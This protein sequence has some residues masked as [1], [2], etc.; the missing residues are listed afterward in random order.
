MPHD[1]NHGIGTGPRSMWYNMCA[2]W[3]VCRALDYR[4]SRLQ[5][6]R[7]LLRS[8]IVLL[9]VPGLP[10]TLIVV[11]ILFHGINHAFKAGDSWA[12]ADASTAGK[13]TSQSYDTVLG[14]GES[15][16]RVRNNAPAMI[17]LTAAELEALESTAVCDVTFTPVQREL[18]LELRRISQLPE[19]RRA[20]ALERIRPKLE[21]LVARIPDPQRSIIY[22]DPSLKDQY[23]RAEGLP[24]EQRLTE[25]WRLRKIAV[26]RMVK[27]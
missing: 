7:R 3:K 27:R 12:A 24:R 23:V 26:S 25:I 8:V 6:A 13:S 19:T 16:I 15:I 2:E 18:Q 11:S 14:P 4:K 1:G 5:L 20:A 9:L 21:Q 17:V 22:E 10:I